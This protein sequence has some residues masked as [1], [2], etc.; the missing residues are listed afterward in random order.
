MT[1]ERDTQVTTHYLIHKKKAKMMNKPVKRYG[2]PTN[3]EAL[4]ETVG[5]LVPNILILSLA[6]YIAKYY[7]SACQVFSPVTLFH[8]WKSVEYG[9]CYRS[10][11]FPPKSMSLGFV[12][13]LYS[14]F[15]LPCVISSPI[16][17]IK[18]P[19]QKVVATTLNKQHRIQDLKKE[20]AYFS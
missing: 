14:T 9:M 5:I 17:K 3:H 18:K 6:H 16:R 2:T 15:H 11:K 10:I 1:R 8:K 13:H 12:L 7:R 20:K 4:A 19:R